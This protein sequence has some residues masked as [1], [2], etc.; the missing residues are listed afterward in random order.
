LQE[1]MDRMLAGRTALVIA[2]R[3]ATVVAADRILVVHAGKLVEEG[4]HDELYAQNGVYRD[5]FDLQ[6][7]SAGAA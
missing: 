7:K 5:L 3:L 1:S 6:F 2:H 4:S